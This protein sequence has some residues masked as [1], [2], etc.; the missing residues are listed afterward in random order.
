MDLFDEQ[1]SLVL[2][3]F[4]NPNQSFQPQN[5]LG[6][7]E[8]RNNPTAK[9][10]FNPYD[11]LW[12]LNW[13]TFST[14]SSNFVVNLWW[15]YIINDIYLFDGNGSYSWSDNEA[16]QA[17]IWTAFSYTTKIMFSSLTG[18]WVWTR[19]TSFSATPTQYIQFRFKHGAGT[20]N[21]IVIDWTYI[22]TWESYEQTGW[23]TTY[24]T[25]NEIIGMNIVFGSPEQYW[26]KFKYNR[27]YEAFSTTINPDD[28][29]SFQ[30]NPYN[31]TVWILDYYRDRWSVILPVF[32]WVPRSM[33]DPADPKQG[34][35][36]FATF[37]DRKPIDYNL[38]TWTPTQ[39]NG[40]GFAVPN[41][42][43]IAEIP[44]SYSHKAYLSKKLA[45]YLWPN[46]VNNFTDMIEL[47]NENDWY[48]FWAWNM[49]PYEMAAMMSADYDGH[50]NTMTYSWENV[51]VK[52]WDSDMKISIPALANHDLRYFRAM[53]RWFQ[54]YRKNCSVV[55][56][57]DI[58]NIHAY[59]NS[60]GAQFIAAEWWGVAP[61]TFNMREE[62]QK[63][64]NFRNKYVPGAILANT[65]YWY[66]T[67]QEIHPNPTH[68]YCWGAI[69]WD[70]WVNTRPIWPFDVREIQWQWLIRT[71]FEFAAAGVDFSN[72]F[73]LND[74]YTE[75]N[76]CGVFWLA[77]LLEITWSSWYTTYYWP[78][79]SWNYYM[80][81][82]NTIW[83]MHYHSDY[84]LLNWLWWTWEFIVMKFQD[85]TTGSIKSYIVWSPTEQNISNNAFFLPF[86]TGWEARVIRLDSNTESWTQLQYSAN[87]TGLTI[88]VT[89]K[90]IIILLQ[91]WITWNASP[92][93]SNASPIVYSW[94]TTWF[95][96]TLP[97]LSAYITVWWTSDSD[98]FISSGFWSY[99]SWPSSV[100][101]TSPN[102][103]ATQ[104]Q[105]F[106]VWY[107]NFRYTAI[108]NQWATWILDVILRV[109][110]AVLSWNTSIVNPSGWFWW[111]GGGGS[112][113]W[114]WWS[115][116]Y[117]PINQPV[118]QNAVLPAANFT[119][120]PSPV[121]LSPKS[122]EELA[123]K[124]SELS[125]KQWF[126][127]ACNNLWLTDTNIK[128]IS[129][130]WEGAIIIAKYL[131]SIWYNKPNTKEKCTIPDIW[132]TSTLMYESIISLCQKWIMWANNKNFRPWDYLKRAEFATILSRISRWSTFENSSAPYYWKHIKQ[133]IDVGILTNG[134]PNLHEKF[135]Y[136]YL[137][138]QKHSIYSKK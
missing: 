17:Y 99:I 109:Q 74:Q 135:I 35:T 60:L 96:V 85:N 66:D 44:A 98:W 78:K 89:E 79:P 1:N 133:V 114:I 49:S 84:R 47:W 87:T 101:I 110:D 36:E 93:P 126:L 128:N 115:T 5:C 63:W 132:N 91:E 62:M 37:Q 129:S 125:Y 15:R 111:W 119:K 94:W 13:S 69:F 23:S 112:Y 81:V 83:N 120:K 18:N 4:W 92:P 102:T 136:L 76:I 103:F 107:Y 48:W 25:L 27:L 82:K 43:W 130:R 50:C 108:D 21:E 10:C 106:V 75:P 16:I 137:W 34:T 97:S 30:T 104:I 7:W 46:G 68:P 138:L 117:T 134:N 32:Q 52:N 33:I 116:T 86:S 20:I 31:Y 123:K 77:G 58:I 100:L 64:V 51:W 9:I 71:I 80:T 105:W 40:Y 70:S 59:A 22:G 73:W 56:P 95:S 65:E 113:W 118:T 122:C 54:H 45:T 11:T 29:L 14:N 90:P 39:I 38:C 28:T 127:F 67:Y 55:V 24:N 57:I 88:Q 42:E 12:V 2:D 6:F 131:S 61:E 124:I 121:A 8:R 3:W 19:H 41:C 53:I 72:L 26:S